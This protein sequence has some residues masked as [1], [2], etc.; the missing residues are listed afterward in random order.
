MTPLFLLFRALVAAPSPLVGE[1]C[2]T[3]RSKLVWERGS[4]K[5]R[6]LPRRTAS[7][8]WGRGEESER[9]AGVKNGSGAPSVGF[10]TSF[11]FWPIFSLSG[12]QSTMLVCT[13]GPSFNVT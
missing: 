13:E 6:P 3:A 1:G 9:Y 5:H 7:L 8:R 4:G 12:S 11:T 10:H 2:T